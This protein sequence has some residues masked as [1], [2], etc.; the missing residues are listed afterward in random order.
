M[1]GEQTVTGEAQ[2]GKGFFERFFKFM[3]TVQK[4]LYKQSINARLK[5][6]GIALLFFLLM[7]YIP[8]YG[9]QP[10][11]AS[12]YLKTLEILLGSK[13]GSLMTL[14]IGPIVT[15]GIVLQLLVGSKILNWDM[16]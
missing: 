11:Q 10:G 4:P 3:P 7:S 6:T 14:G 1:N 2:E 15:A 8:V 5:W 9:L 12:S 16:T 13:V